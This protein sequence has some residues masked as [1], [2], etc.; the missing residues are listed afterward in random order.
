[1]WSPHYPVSPVVR[2]L[3]SLLL[4]LI[5]S[6]NGLGVAFARSGVG[7]CCREHAQTAV[8]AETEP[9]HFAPT[10]EPAGRSI[11]SSRQD[12]I[13]KDSQHLDID[14]CPHCIGVGA[15]TPML[16][17]SPRTS[18]SLLTAPYETPPYRGV[19]I[20]GERPGRLERPPSVPFLN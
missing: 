4:S 9:C 8:R 2:R 17:M 15:S 19:V 7:N 6:I 12:P 13:H 10:Q 14:L 5:L 18:V 16:L 11:E 1:M 3:L 20:P